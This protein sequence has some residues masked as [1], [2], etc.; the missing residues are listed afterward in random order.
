MNRLGVNVYLKIFLN[1]RLVIKIEFLLCLLSGDALVGDGGSS[2]AGAG[3]VRQG[4]VMLAWQGLSL[5][6]SGSPG[7]SLLSV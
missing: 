2:C 4:Q 1:S 6:Y 5:P 7:G 3:T